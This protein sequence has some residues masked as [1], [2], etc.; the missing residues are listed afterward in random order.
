M[1]RLIIVLVLAL[2]L[3]PGAVQAAAPTEAAG[4]VAGIVDLDSLVLTPRGPNCL[5]T[6]RGLHVWSGT[7]TGSGYITS[8]IVTKRP[9]DEA[10]PPFTSAESIHTVGTF[11]GTVSGRAGSFEYHYDLQISGPTAAKGEMV[12]EHGSDGLAGIH[13]VLRFY[14]DWVCLDC[15]TSTYTGQINFAP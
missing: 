10:I 9:C 1:K 3:V 6:L 8:R 15:P 12:I 13:G 11:T 5:I 14:D 4:Q 7:L 2:G